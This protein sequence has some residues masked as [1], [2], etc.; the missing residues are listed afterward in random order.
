MRDAFRMGP[1]RGDSAKPRPIL[2]YFQSV[3]DVQKVLSSL[4]KLK[5][6]GEKLYISRA[7]CKQDRML[8]KVLL[9]KRHELISSGTSRSSI[10][11]KG[12]KLYVDGQQVECQNL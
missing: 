5:T 3:W 12:L 2:A 9:S 8:E 1:Y 4:N 10:S 6:F 7:L 11:I